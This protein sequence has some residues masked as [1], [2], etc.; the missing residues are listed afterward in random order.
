MA[1]DDAAAT[2]VESPEALTKAFFEKLGAVQQRY[3]SERVILVRG[4][5]LDDDEDEDEDDEEEEDEEKEGAKHAYTAEQLALVR[6]VFLTSRR[7]QTIDE[8]M[9]FVTGGQAGQFFM[10]FNTRYG[11]NVCLGIA[12]RVAKALKLKTLPEQF[13]SLFGLTFALNEQDYWLHDN[14][15]CER[16]G[17]LE[18]GLKALAKAWKTVLANTDSSLGIDSEYTRAGIE[19]LLEIMEEKV[20]KQQRGEYEVGYEFNWR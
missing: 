6:Y 7:D 18:K 14:E 13:D 15:F 4:V 2:G 3:A 19:A 9:N 20:G 11:N 12:E 10:M 1:T 8:A 17:A 16:K 5:K